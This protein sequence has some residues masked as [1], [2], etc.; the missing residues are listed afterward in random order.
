MNLEPYCPANFV[1]QTEALYVDGVGD[2]D[3]D[4]DEDGDGDGD[5]YLARHRYR[6]IQSWQE[7]YHGLALDGHLHLPRAFAIAV[8]DSACHEHLSTAIHKT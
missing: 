8:Q 3:G 5:G 2:G 4:G 6:K 1:A 7:R